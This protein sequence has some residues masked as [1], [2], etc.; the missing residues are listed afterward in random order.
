MAVKAQPKLFL[1][2]FL[3]SSASRKVRFCLAEKGLAYDEHI[4]DA[5]ALEH[6]E[7]W[8][9]KIH[10]EGVVPALLIDDRIFRESNLINEYLDLR[11]P[12]PPLR[13]DGAEERYELQQ[14]SRHMDEVVRR[15]FVKFNLM[16][17]WRPVASLWSDEQLE[18]TMAA[19]PT[20]ERR[21]QMRRAA[22]E[23]YSDTELAQSLALGRA[24]AGDIENRLAG[25]DWLFGGRFGL[26]EINATPYVKR[27]SELEPAALSPDLRPR[28]ADW[29]GRITS[30]AGYTAA[31]IVTAPPANIEMDGLC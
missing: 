31:Q 2:H 8:Y 21:E 23:P 15:A 18:R 9:L 4:I 22:R 30:R 20:E 10:P 29:W 13:P 11:F 3:A 5:V 24:M 7:D 1:Y 19:V 17:F 14:W 6:L 28:L 27:L 25:K 26:G 16:Q 12:D